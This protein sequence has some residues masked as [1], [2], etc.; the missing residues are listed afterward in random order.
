MLH[1]THVKLIPV[2]S[3]CKHN[4]DLTTYLYLK[5]NEDGTGQFVDK[6]RHL[7]Y[8]IGAIAPEI[9]FDFSEMKLA[10]R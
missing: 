5:D 4:F 2:G 9:T 3:S 10:K 6:K 8:G 7:N 1:Y